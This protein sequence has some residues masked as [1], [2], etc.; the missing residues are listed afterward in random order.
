MYVYLMVSRPAPAGGVG[1]ILPTCEQMLFLNIYMYT[2]VCVCVC[3]CVLVC[4]DP[5]V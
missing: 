4:I 3:V 5:Y 2:C 1:G